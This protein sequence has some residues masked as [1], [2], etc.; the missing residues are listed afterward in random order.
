MSRHQFQRPFSVLD[1][2]Q[3]RVTLLTMKEFG[4]TWDQAKDVIAYGCH[5]HDIDSGYPEQS[6]EYWMVAYSL[7][8]TKLEKERKL[9]G[10]KSSFE[11][12][13]K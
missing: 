9:F 1:D 5:K 11:D 4:L 8:A 13:T 7:G 12:G 6:P 10:G 2:Y 3:H